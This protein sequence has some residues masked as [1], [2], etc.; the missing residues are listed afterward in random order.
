ME[1]TAH[2]GGD[3]MDY[4]PS[5][6]VSI[7]PGGRTI[8]LI[9]IFLII[10]ILASLPLV[11]V[12][13]S[14]SGRGII[15][16]LREKT[17]IIAATSGIVDEVY[18]NEGDRIQESEPL[19]KIRS[20]ETKKNLQSL[21]MELRETEAHIYDLG[22]LTSSPLKVPCSPKYTREYEEYLDRIAYLELLHTKVKREFSRHESLYRAGLISGKEY[23]D[24]VF[25]EE[26]AVKELENLKSQSLSHWQNEYY[27]QLG[28][29]R[30]L[31]TQ[32][33]STEE[34]IR[35]TTVHAPATGNLVEFKGIFEGSAVHTGS[36]IG[37]LSPE[38]GLIGEFYVSSGDIAFLRTGQKVHL[39]LDA[40]SAR[41]WGILPGCIYEISSDF[42]LLDKQ[43]VY[44]VK[45][46]I[47]RTELHLRNG[48]A[49]KIKKGMSFQ[50]RCLV[51]RRTLFHLLADKA[52]NWLNPALP[53]KNISVIP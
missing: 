22:R 50:A 19:L 3:F 47:E 20:V 4:L 28:R 30:D 24:L 1:K 38:S 52:D 48:Y 35:L 53:G 23:D 40:F 46:R 43:P 31:Q 11:S 2:T 13:V 34:K 17:R 26:K 10:G 6:L 21:N 16:P 5:Y 8:Y 44:R 9:S 39:H 32:I 15:R 18:V 42:L 36:V 29:L 33:R 49:G 37:V 7:H 51:T 12:Q 27:G 14:V 25:E 45:C 41:E